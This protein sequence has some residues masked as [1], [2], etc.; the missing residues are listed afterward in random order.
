M[1]RPIVEKK[2]RNVK[3]AYDDLDY[4]DFDKVILRQYVDFNH[5]NLSCWIYM[6][7][8]LFILFYFFYL[9]INVDLVN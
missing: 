6:P 5:T 2:Y 7:L 1:F 8:I 9:K 4:Q 3:N